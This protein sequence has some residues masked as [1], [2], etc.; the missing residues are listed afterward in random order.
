MDRR[1]F[2]VVQGQLDAENTAVERADPLAFQADCVAAYEASWIARGFSPVTIENGVG[3]LGRA[4]DL[5]GRTAWEADVDDIDRLVVVWLPTACRARSGADM[6]RR[7]RVFTGFF[8]P[9]RPPGSRLPSASGSCVPLMSST[10]RVMSV[11]RALRCCPRRRRSDWG[12]LRLFAWTDP[13]RAQVRAGG[14]GL[15]VVQDAVSRW[16]PGGR[17]SP[18]RYR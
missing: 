13:D 2:R 9:V 1:G 3:L 12:I 10:R 14:K 5:L 4:L 18:G 6:F 15:R 7:S 11:T 17:G 16:A 8:R